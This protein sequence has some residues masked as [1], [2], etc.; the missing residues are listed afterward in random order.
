MLVPHE[1]PDARH[2][3]GSRKAVHIDPV[4]SDVG[5]SW[6]AGGLSRRCATALPLHALPGRPFLLR[7]QPQEL[8]RVLDLPFVLHSHLSRTACGRPGHVGGVPTVRSR[9][10]WRGCG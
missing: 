3:G 4:P 10:L 7:P 8:A 5:R 6:R 9:W 2:G 1:D